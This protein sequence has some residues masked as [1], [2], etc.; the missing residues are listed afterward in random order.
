[1]PGTDARMDALERI[2]APADTSNPCSPLM[3]SRDAQEA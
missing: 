2:S 3:Q 1:M